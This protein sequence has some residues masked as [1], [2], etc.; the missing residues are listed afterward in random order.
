MKLLWFIVGYV[1]I[2]AVLYIAMAVRCKKKPVFKAP[3]SPTLFYV[4]SFTWGLPSVLIGGIVALTLRIAGNKPKKYGLEWY[5]EFPNIHWGLELG[6]FFIAPKGCYET[7]KMHEHGH[8]IQNV[9][10]GIFTPLVVFLP[11][12]VRFWYREFRAA[13]GKPCKTAYS[14]IWFEKS[15]DESGK[16]LMR[17]LNSGDRITPVETDDF[18]GCI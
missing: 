8:G 7:L 2:S 15:A 13:I 3:R 12:A 14:S 1:V 11:S 4:L 5:F 16:Y 6:I 17:K 9:Y 18:S 10:F